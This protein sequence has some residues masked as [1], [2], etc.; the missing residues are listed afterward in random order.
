MAMSD[1]IDT[2][3]LAV[4]GFVSTIVVLLIVL[5]V[6]IWYYQLTH[7]FSQTRNVQHVD[8][9]LARYYVEQEEKLHRL[10]WAD[11]KAHKVAIPI[12]RAME[13]TLRDL[14]R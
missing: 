14:K 4:V 5:L 6:Q 3:K 12:D 1:E 13:L 8:Q 11:A 10:E 7:D 9:A 2:P